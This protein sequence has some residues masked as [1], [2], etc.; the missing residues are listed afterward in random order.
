MSQRGY[1]FR[2]GGAWYLRYRDDILG[3]DGTP[4]RLQFC[5]K[6]A[7]Y[8]SIRFRSKAQVKPLADEILAP[9]NNGRVRPESTM[10]VE[11]F[12]EG[13]Y[14]PDAKQVMRPSTYKNAYN[15]WKKHLA[16]RLTGIRLRDFRTAD[17]E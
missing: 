9:L 4:R 14:F 17:G 10:V 5:R 3:P 2:K 12:V 16:H 1:I 8:D 7:D 11:Q 6:L 13:R 15:L